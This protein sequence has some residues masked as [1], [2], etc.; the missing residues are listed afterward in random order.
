MKIGDIV[1]QKIPPGQNI[2]CEN[3]CSDSAVAYFDG[4]PFCA[5]CLREE[6][7]LKWNAEGQFFE[8][9]EGERIY[10]EVVERLI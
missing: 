8:N 2:Q 9:S 5:E 4:T 6:Q 1:V 10:Y 7:Q 3:E